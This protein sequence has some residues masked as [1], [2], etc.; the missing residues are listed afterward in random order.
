MV[1]P[2]TPTG[3]AVNKHAIAVRAP[4]HHR[5]L[6]PVLIAIA[7]IGSPSL[8]LARGGYSAKPPRPFTKE[9]LLLIE[10]C[11]ALAQ[12]QGRE[13]PS[14]AQQCSSIRPYLRP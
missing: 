13:S 11:H 6:L 4:P 7:M 14:F 2:T 5:P 1:A 12:S 3:S 10:K 9:E 8:A